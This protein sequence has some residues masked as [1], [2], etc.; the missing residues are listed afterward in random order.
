MLPRGYLPPHGMLLFVM[1]KS[2]TVPR[3]LITGASD[4]IGLALAQHYHWRGAHLLLVARRPAATLPPELRAHPYLR[5]DLAQ[6]YAADVVAAWLA[7]QQVDHVDLLVHNAAAGYYGAVHTQPA[8]SIAHLL[9]LNLWAPLALTHRLLPLLPGGKVV[10]VGSVATALPAPDYAVYAATK[11]A[12]AGF[13]RAVR[14]ELAPDVQ[15]QVIHPGATRTAMHARSGAAHLDTARY[16]DPQQVAVQLATAISAGDAVAVLGTTNRV[17]WRAG[18]TTPDAV[19]DLLR[20]RY[21]LP[22]PLTVAPARA[23]ADTPHCVIT[24]AAAGIGRELALACAAAGYHVTGI[25]RD[26]PSAAATLADLQERDPTARFIVADLAR[27]AELERLLADLPPRIDLLVQN[28]G[29]SAAGAFAQLDLAAQHAV[30]A[31]NMYAPL[32]LTPLLLQRGMLARGSTLVFVSSL[33]HY[34]GYPGA[35]VYAASKDGIAAYARSLGVALAP[36]DMHVTTVFP[37]PTRTD[38]ARRYSP[39]NRR[40][41]QRMPPADVAQA[42]LRAVV[43][44]QRRVIPGAS[45]RVLARLGRVAPGVFDGIMKQMLYEPLMQGVTHTR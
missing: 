32:L 43:T 3:I 15:V 38:H 39:D 44:R 2:T 25:D 41:Q 21:R 13:A 9:H 31:V 11:A 45:N 4:G 14:I 10:F 30:L 12:L 22:A 16:A 18:R 40:E 23:P 26:A 34:L 19:D 8:A 33:S 24:G 27:P 29:I 36:A 6:P 35:A 28:A 7:Q 42:I 17:L 1:A 37:G 5:C 20:A